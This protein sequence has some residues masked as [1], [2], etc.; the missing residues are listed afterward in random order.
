MSVIFLQY[1]SIDDLGED[2]RITLPLHSF[3]IGDVVLSAQSVF[4]LNLTY[5]RLTKVFVQTFKDNHFGDE[6]VVLYGGTST[7]KILTVSY[8][9]TKRRNNVATS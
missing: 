8:Q 7:G 4:E 6:S 1:A 2:C 5:G 9:E 3:V